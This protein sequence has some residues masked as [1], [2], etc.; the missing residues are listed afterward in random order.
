[1]MKNSLILGVLGLILPG[2]ASLV[3]PDYCYVA[4]VKKDTAEQVERET[5]ECDATTR[6]PKQHRGCMRLRGYVVQE[7]TNENRFV[8]VSE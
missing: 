7:C 8:R 6:G 3:P 2:C 1:M 4:T 5:A